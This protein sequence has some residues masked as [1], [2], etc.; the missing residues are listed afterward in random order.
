MNKYGQYCP[1]ARAVEILGDRWT[2]LIVR[3]LLF[4]AQHFNELEGGLPGIPKALLS[5]RLRRLQHIGA[6]VRQSEPGRRG[7]RYQLTQAGWELYPV[8]ESLT[9]W[10]AKWA[11]GEP[12]PSELNPVLLLWW[13]R[14][15]TKREKLPKQRVVVEFKFTQTRPKRFWLVLDAVDVSVCV[16]HP[17][18]DIDMLV[19]ADL[20]T[21]YEVLLGRITFARA[22]NE[23]RLQIDATPALIKE[24]PKWF[25]LSPV[26]EIVKATLAGNDNRPFK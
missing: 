13:M 22:I 5:E 1:T 14:D 18:F 8:I 24:F 3:D 19:E 6:I 2:L 21:L 7:T 23:E 11:F 9:H 12:E 26:A 10:G 15:L 20:A 25:A 16:K 4:G 17:G